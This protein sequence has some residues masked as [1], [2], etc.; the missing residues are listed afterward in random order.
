MKKTLVKQSKY[1][2]CTHCGI[3]VY[4]C[5]GCKEYILHSDREIYCDENESS[6]YCLDC[7]K[8]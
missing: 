2:K 4:V 6:H 5:E 3:H 7:G 1:Y 8:E